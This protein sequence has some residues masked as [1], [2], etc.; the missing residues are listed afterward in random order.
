MTI[1]SIIAPSVSAL[2]KVPFDAPNTFGFTN[3]TGVRSTC[4]GAMALVAKNVARLQSIADEVR[5]ST[6]P[7][8]TNIPLGTKFP[9]R[10]EGN[11]IMINVVA[12]S[13]MFAPIAA[14]KGGCRENYE[15]KILP[16]RKDA[17]IQYTGIQLTELHADVWMQVL[18]FA[19]FHT[20]GAPFVVNRSQFLK[21]MDCGVGGADYKRLYSL[22][23][24]LR[25]AMVVITKFTPEGKK[26]SVSKAMNVISHFE[27]DHQIDEYALG[28]DPD[29]LALYGNQEFSV[30][31]NEKR[32]I[33]R[34]PTAK[35]LQRLIATSN[36]ITQ[37]HS[38][39]MLKEIFCA[40]SPLRKFKI[41]VINAVAE[42]VKEK[43][44]VSGDIELSTKAELQLKIVKFT[45]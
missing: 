37:K 35:A 34:S 3:D 45:G 13:G 41:S 39:A 44:L 19:S 4:K 15:D 1:D 10:G 40:S 6:T 25:A 29:W 16:G 31:D 28:I 17:K 8:A 20:A 9:T 32:K 18:H 21:A 36:S 5:V 43:V 24:E 26:K 23:L 11:R 42:L 7:T 2:K 38:L 33:L 27:Y 12:R 14:P 22:L 30:I